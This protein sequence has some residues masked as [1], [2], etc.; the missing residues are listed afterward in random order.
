MPGNQGASAYHKLIERILT[1]L[2]YPDLINPKRE[3][4]IHDGRKRID[5]TYDNVAKEGFFSW[6]AQHYKAPKIFIEC[7]NYT[8]DVGNEELDQLSGRFSPQ[9]GRIGLITSRNFTDKAAFRKRCRDT[10]QDNRG[11]VIALDDADVT[12]LVNARI[13]SYKGPELTL[14]QEQFDALVM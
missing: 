7:K 2:M 6:V 14:L 8:S 3:E 4:K 12:Q 10:A 13:T 9:R 11:F 1:P 5:I